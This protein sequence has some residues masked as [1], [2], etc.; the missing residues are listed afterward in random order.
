MAI[1]FHDFIF[2]SKM[3]Y[4]TETVTT[5]I[6]EEIAIRKKSSKK[7]IARVSEIYDDDSSPVGMLLT[8]QRFFRL[9]AEIDFFLF[10]K[11][12]I[13]DI[14][15]EIQDMIDIIEAEIEFVIGEAFKQTLLPAANLTNTCI[16]VAY[17][18]FWENRW[19][20]IFENMEK[21]P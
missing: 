6:D 3:Y 20:D 14:N 1:N 9:S 4:N 16:A 10:L 8:S 7:W 17:R 19:K 15:L 21:M 11:N 12:Q 2:L 13:K 5:M 18:D